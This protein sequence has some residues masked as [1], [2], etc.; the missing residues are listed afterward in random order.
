MEWLPIFWLNQKSSK[1][2]HNTGF[3]SLELY[4][5]PCSPDLPR[6]SFPIFSVTYNKAMIDIHYET[7]VTSHNTFCRRLDT[8]SPGSPRNI[9]HPELLVQANFR[10][11][12]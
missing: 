8:V 4:R 5:K 11:K 1:L 10:E 7:A 6:Q 3:I 9:G 12:M 2:S